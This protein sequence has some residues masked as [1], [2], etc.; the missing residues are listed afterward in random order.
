[1]DGQCRHRALTCTR[2][3]VPCSSHSLPSPSGNILVCL[4]PLEAGGGTCCGCLS[5]SGES[6]EP[7]A[8]ALCQT[9]DKYVGWGVWG[10]AGVDTV[11]SCPP[12]DARRK[13]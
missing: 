8:A 1:M 11:Q 12:S 13:H 2:K 10:T 4:S 7:D 3:H 6:W 5:P 9:G